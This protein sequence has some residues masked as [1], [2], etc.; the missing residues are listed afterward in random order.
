MY[1]DIDKFI[2]RISDNMLW[3]ASPCEKLAYEELL[4]NRPK[5]SW[6]IEDERILFPKRLTDGN[7]NPSF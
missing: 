5:T 3:Y 1:F 4:I 7:K 6:D 2:N